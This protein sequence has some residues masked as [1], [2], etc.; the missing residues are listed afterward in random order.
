MQVA[1]RC[2]T[3]KYVSGTEKLVLHVPQFQK[4]G[5][6][7]EFPGGA[8]ICHYGPNKC[9]MEGYFNICSESLTFG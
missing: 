1:D 3:C 4:I 6:C 9:F 7:G 8:R 2:E 5:V